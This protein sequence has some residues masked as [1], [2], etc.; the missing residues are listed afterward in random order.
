MASVWTIGDIHGEYEKLAVLL[1]ALPRKEDDY[2]VFLGDF[3]DRGP[4]SKSVVRR[5]L[6]EYEAAPD[7][8]ILL[9]GNHEDMAAANYG[10]EGTPS[11]FEYDPYDWFRNGGL[12]AMESYG[13]KTPEVF[14]EK[15]PA[16]LWQLFGLLKTFWRAP[17][18]IFPELAHCIWVHA[19]ILPGQQPEDAGGDVLLWVREDFLNFLDM[20]GR[21]VLHGHTPFKTVRVLP[22]KIGLDTGAVF[23]GLLSGLQLPERIL[24]Q[25][26]DK[27]AIHMA[28]PEPPSVES[29]TTG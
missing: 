15:C 1:D 13:L 29:L 25:A 2:T 24:Y 6:D 12:Q 26:N 9:W 16:D 22:D 27:T 4:D 28:L 11:P 8:T 3:I 19:G 18:D 20:S 21:L 7:R 10:W 23:G 14:T 17:Q 5:V